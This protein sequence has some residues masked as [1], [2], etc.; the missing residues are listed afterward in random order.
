[1]KAAARLTGAGP[2]A[3]ALADR[4]SDTWIAFAKTG[5]P[6]TPKLPRWTPFNATDRPTM[7]IDNE[8]KLV[9][10]PIREQRL[11]MF[12]ALEYA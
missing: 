4:V 12:K 6:N 1:V 5:D 3:M 11:V 8:S 2:E 9:N 7:V 10:D